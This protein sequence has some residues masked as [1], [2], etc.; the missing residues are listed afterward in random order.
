VIFSLFFP[1]ESQSRIEAG[2][3]KSL[4]ANG[5]L[6]FSP[7]LRRLGRYP[8]E[9][10]HKSINPNGVAAIPLLAFGHRGHNP[11][12]VVLKNRFYSARPRPQPK[13]AHESHKYTR[14]EDS[15][16]CLFFSSESVKS[17]S[18]DS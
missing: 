13:K 7:G 1:E 15:R 11:F 8:G 17:V 6:A 10:M 2:I 4:D 12:R 5:V 9:T 14:M 16:R 18:K 3:L